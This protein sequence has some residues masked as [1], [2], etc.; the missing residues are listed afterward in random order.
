MNFAMAKEE[1][2]ESRQRTGWKEQGVGDFVKGRFKPGLQGHE[3]IAKT[4]SACR[5]LAHDVDRRIDLAPRAG[6]GL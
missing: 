4:S 3:T 5:R 6:S 2:L 1:E